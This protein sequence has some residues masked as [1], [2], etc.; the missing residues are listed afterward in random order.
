MLVFLFLEIFLI[1]L[2]LII[3]SDVHCDSWVKKKLGEWLVHLSKKSLILCKS[4]CFFFFLEILFISLCLIDLSNVHCD[5]WGKEKKGERLVHL[6]KRFFTLQRL[7][8]AYALW[9]EIQNI[10]QILWGLFSFFS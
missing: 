8:P 7:Q 6:S 1:S 3:L 10:V 5:S 2:Y 4:L 9:P